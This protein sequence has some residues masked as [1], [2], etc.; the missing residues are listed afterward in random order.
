VLLEQH[1]TAPCLMAHTSMRARDRAHQRRLSPWG[2]GLSDR[3]LDAKEQ[4]AEITTRQPPEPLHSMFHVHA[5]DP[6]SVLDRMHIHSCVDAC[7]QARQSEQLLQNAVVD[8]G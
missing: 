6:E 8:A 5:V 2:D 1:S 3:L 4:P 7:M